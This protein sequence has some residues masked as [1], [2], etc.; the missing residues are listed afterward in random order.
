MNV[1][2]IPIVIGTFGTIPKRLIKRIEDLEL[3]GQV[4]N[5]IIRIGKNTEKSPGDLRKLAVT[6]SPVR[7][8]KLM[9]V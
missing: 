6:R 8:N 9:L 5:S 4:D 1:P 7:N 3:I 2:V